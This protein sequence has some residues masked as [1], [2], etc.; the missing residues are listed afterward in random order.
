MQWLLQHHQRLHGPVFGGDGAWLRHLHCRTA[1]Y[2]DADPAAHCS[3]FH[4]YFAA[5]FKS[6]SSTVNTADKSTKFT[7]ALPSD[8]KTN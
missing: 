2:L 1:A 8:I 7:A 4:A 5:D 3:P 6:F